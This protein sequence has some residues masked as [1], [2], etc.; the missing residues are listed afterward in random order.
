MGA[1][2]VFGNHLS[3]EGIKHY[4]EKIKHFGLCQ[5]VNNYNRMKT[6]ENFSFKWGDEIEHYIISVNEKNKT[7]NLCLSGDEFLKKM[8]KFNRSL[9]IKQ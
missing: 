4:I 9:P 3:D 1:L 2:N 6:K 7:I 8:K 5:F